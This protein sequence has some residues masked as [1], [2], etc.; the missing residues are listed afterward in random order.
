MHD[1]FFSV[2]FEKNEEAER[3]SSLSEFNKAK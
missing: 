3:S 1:F 2:Y